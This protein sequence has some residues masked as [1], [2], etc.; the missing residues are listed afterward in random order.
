MS[1]QR[2]QA[3]FDT[4]TACSYYGMSFRSLLAHNPEALAA[5]ETL[6]ECLKQSDNPA[7]R[8]DNDKAEQQRRDEKRGL[9]PEHEDGSN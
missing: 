9:H 1:F 8:E 2:S 4:I 7:M 6:A 5:A 3:A